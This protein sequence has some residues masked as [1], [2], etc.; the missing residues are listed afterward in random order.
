MSF[1]S[2]SFLVFLPLVLVL[3]FLLPKKAKPVLLLVASYFFYAF[4]DYKLIFLILF[5]TGLSYLMAR[6][7][8]RK[9]GKLKKALLVIYLIVALGTL[10]AFKYLNFAIG[11]GLSIAKLFGITIDPF[12]I[13][14]VLPVGISFY[15]FQ[16]ISYVVDIYMGKKECEKNF[17]IFA[18]FVSYFPQLVA[19]PIEKSENLIPQFKEDHHFNSVDLRYGIQMMLIGYAKKIVVADFLS[20]Y[21]NSVYGNVSSSSG[22]AL[23]IATFMFGIQIYCDFS[24]YSDIAKGISRIMGI[25]LMDNFNKP[26]YSTTIK[27][28][29]NRWHISLND[30]FTEYV[31]IP[32]GGNRKGKA[33]KYLNIF[34]VFALSGLWHGA[35]MHFIVWGIAHGA[36]RI[37]GD[38]SAPIIEKMTSKGNRGV[39][40]FL[41]FISTFILINLVWVFFRASSIGD[42]LTAFQR[43]FTFS[44]GTGLDYFN[45]STIAHLATAIL[46]LI[47][48]EYLPAFDQ[49]VFETKTISLLTMAYAA[50]FITITIAW[51]YTVSTV[52][53][54]QFIYFQF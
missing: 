52:G 22:F 15:T 43:I 10:F 25:R 44:P 53:E 38:A 48:V 17:I 24:G 35:S 41:G 19:G 30:F 50:L 5:S 34:I 11:T 32:L 39:W 1:T 6:I 23:L 28:F 54:S 12:V 27:D 8:E 16:T 20:I 13:N 4:A 49:R 31:Y 18:L 9:N 26:Y 21:V 3:Y 40:K 37:I 33:R 45:V 47:I 42:A 29:W 7:I 36:L 46:L 14:I 2:L 51:I